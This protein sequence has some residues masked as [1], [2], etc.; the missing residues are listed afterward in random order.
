VGAGSHNENV[1]KQ[2]LKE[3]RRLKRTGK[4]SLSLSGNPEKAVKSWQTQP[5]CVARN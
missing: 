4:G 2:R 1:L 5:V 3:I